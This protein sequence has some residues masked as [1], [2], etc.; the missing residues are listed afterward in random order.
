MKSIT[1]VVPCYNEEKRL[2]LDAFTSYASQNTHVQIL[3]VD[4]GSI[5]HT[6]QMIEKC[7]NENSQIHALKMPK[8]SGKA[9]AVR[10]GM[11]KS[12]ENNSD[13][14]GFWDADL[15]TPLDQL[16]L[17]QSYMDR[18]AQVIM[19]SR[20]NL[21]GRHIERTH[22][23]HYLGRLFATFASIVLNLG[24]YDTQCGAKLFRK[25]IVESAFSEKFQSY[26]IFDVEILARLRFLNKLNVAQ[27][28]EVPLNIWRDVG[29]SK[30]RPFDFIKAP[31]ELMAIY[32]K[33][34]KNGS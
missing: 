21:L 26:W 2:N 5:D 1:L 28:F 32:V 30:V 29:G 25:D 10:S 8:N 4:D 3:F 15:A 34:K 17:F 33:Y 7:S 27:V 11:L 22:L 24:V 6:W 16:E 31:L 19:G 14:I 23:R 12:L 13:Y 9:E 20:I 18:Q